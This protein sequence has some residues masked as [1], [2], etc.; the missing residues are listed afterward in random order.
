MNNTVD[1]KK[2]EII[3]YCIEACQ[4]ASSAGADRIELCDNPGDGGTTPSLGMTSMAL[5]ISGIP[6]FPMVRPRGGD[7]LFSDLEFSIMLR[8]VRTFRELGCKGVVFG[9]LNADGTVDENRTSRLVDEARDMEVTFHRA[10]DRV[11][12]T[13]TALEA[14]IRC[15]CSRILSSGGFPTAP[16]G[17]DVIKQ[18]QEQAAGRII[19]M[20]GSGIRSTNIS[21]IITVTGC[22]EIHSSAASFSHSSMQFLNDRMKEDLKHPVPDPAEIRHMKATLSI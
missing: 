16:E 5:E 20:P 13:Q 14:V 22:Q 7:F 6:V 3:A 18:L 11:R 9:L 10:F 19:I 4:L 15:G 12:D 1:H 8:D 21:E 2:L 17:M